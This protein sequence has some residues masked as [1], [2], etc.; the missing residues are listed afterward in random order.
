[1]NIDNHEKRLGA[2]KISIINIFFLF[3]YNRYVMTLA[4]NNKS[5]LAIKLA[6]NDCLASLTLPWSM[7]VVSR[8]L[9]ILTTMVNDLVE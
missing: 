5:R 8:S 4:I 1:M 6:S 7:S 3:D 9:Q 2:T